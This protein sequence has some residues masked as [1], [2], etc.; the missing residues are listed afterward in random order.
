MSTVFGRD[1][2]DF[3]GGCGEVTLYPR[4]TNLGIPMKVEIFFLMSYK[5]VI[6]MIY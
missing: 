4:S 2:W 6:K 3:K 1:C 5:Q